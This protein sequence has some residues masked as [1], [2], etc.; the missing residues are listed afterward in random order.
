MRSAH[1]RRSMALLASE[2][3]VPVGAIRKRAG[4]A[5]TALQAEYRSPRH[6]NKDDPL[7]ELI[8]SILSQMTTHPSFNRVY[9]RLRS[10]APSWESA[11][12]MPTRRLRAVIRDAGLSR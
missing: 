11:L 9:E 7:D 5:C 8:F 6:G 1:C 12:K 2:W 10:H 3:S 4:Q